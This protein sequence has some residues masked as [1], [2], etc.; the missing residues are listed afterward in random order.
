[1]IFSR[2]YGSSGCRVHGVVRPAADGR[3]QWEPDAQIVVEE[4]GMD[5]HGSFCA[6]FALSAKQVRTF[7]AK[8]AVVTQ[9]QLHD[10]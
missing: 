5:G 9:Q 6:G 7:F 8:A 4:S 2:F 3:L 1:M 10:S